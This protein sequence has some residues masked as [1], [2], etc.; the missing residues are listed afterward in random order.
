MENGLEYDVGKYL[1]LL[2]RAAME[3]LEGL[4]AEA[5]T[6]NKK[7]VILEEVMELPLSWG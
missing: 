1:Q 5:R 7:I 2:E 4:V 6:V 3:I